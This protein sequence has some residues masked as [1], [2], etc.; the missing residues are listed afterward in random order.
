MKDVSFS[1]RINP[2]EKWKGFSKNNRGYFCLEFQS[3]GIFEE[4]VTYP[5]IYAQRQTI[6]TL[7]KLY[8]VLIWVDQKL[9]I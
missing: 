4:R 9:G 3:I 1:I 7:E 6:F 2:D 8:F 5:R